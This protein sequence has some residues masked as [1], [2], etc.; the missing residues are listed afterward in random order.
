MMRWGLRSFGHDWGTKSNISWGNCTLTTPSSFYR[1]QS[2][3]STSPAVT[4]PQFVGPI[5]GSS[6]TKNLRAPPWKRLWADSAARIS[7]C[8]TSLATLRRRKLLPMTIAAKSVKSLSRDQ[9]TRSICWRSAS[10]PI[11]VFGIITIKKWARIKTVLCLAMGTFS[12]IGLYGWSGGWLG[13]QV[14]TSARCTARMNS[15]L[16]RDGLYTTDCSRICSQ[17]TTM[18]KMCGASSYNVIRGLV[19]SRKQASIHEHNN[20]LSRRKVNLWTPWCYWTL[21]YVTMSAW[22]PQAT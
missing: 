10:T 1:A 21:S 17:N 9:R 4:F 8:S 22:L 14:W 12:P 5:H 20:A 16:P 15:I 11:S 7:L 19:F 3:V 18:T 2:F 6:T 13:T